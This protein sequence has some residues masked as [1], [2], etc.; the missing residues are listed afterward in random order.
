MTMPSE[1]S[2]NTRRA[3]GAVDDWARLTPAERVSRCLALAAEAQNC[4][5]HAGLETKEDYLTIAAN[6]IQ[7]ANEINATIGYLPKPLLRL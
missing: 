7:L 2:V 4:A 1:Y 5:N 6:W 3:S